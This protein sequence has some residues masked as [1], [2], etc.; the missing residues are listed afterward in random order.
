MKR[1]IT[2]ML[3][4]AMVAGLLFVSTGCAS[5]RGRYFQTTRQD[6][7]HPFRNRIYNPADYRYTRPN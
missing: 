2:T 6:Q 5:V 4:T 1:A 3:A 7:P